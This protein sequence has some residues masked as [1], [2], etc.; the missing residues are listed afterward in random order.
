[1]ITQ[2]YHFKFSS[3]LYLYSLYFP[4]T[5]NNKLACLFYNTNDHF[6]LCF[7]FINLDLFLITLFVMLTFF[8]PKL[9]VCFLQAKQYVLSTI[10]Y[11]VGN[12]FLTTYFKHFVFMQ[13]FFQTLI[14][15]TYLKVHL[16]KFF[17]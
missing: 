17:S 7:C 4:C 11:N 13:L 16:L 6:L 9:S 14:L 8:E 15:V 3:F 1:M 5:F 10:F 2:V 12:I